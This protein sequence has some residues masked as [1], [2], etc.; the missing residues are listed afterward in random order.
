MSARWRILHIRLK[1]DFS[2]AIANLTSNALPKPEQDKEIDVCLSFP[3][4]VI[5]ATGD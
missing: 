5:E 4:L 2:G 3:N 1:A